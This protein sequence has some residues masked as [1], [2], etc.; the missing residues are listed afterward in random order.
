MFINIFLRATHI[1]VG[2]DQVQH[3]QLAQD[4]AKTFNHR[5]G[6]TFPHPKAV[7]A[8]KIKNHFQI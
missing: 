5:Y 8:G 2:E 3:L 4:I 6:K 1:P 7:V